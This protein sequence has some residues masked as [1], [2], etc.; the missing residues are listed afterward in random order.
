M[1]TFA[2]NEKLNER[3][4]YQNTAD[5]P[6]KEAYDT[7]GNQPYPQK[8]IAD[9]RGYFQFHFALLSQKVASLVFT[10]PILN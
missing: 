4:P 10:R 2:K 5:L 3:R 1:G 6:L 9:R 7:S 8:A